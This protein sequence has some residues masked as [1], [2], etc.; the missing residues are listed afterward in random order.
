MPSVDLLTGRV[1]EDT[2]VDLTDILIVTAKFGTF[3]NRPDTDGYYTEVN[4]DGKVDLTDI[5][6]TNNSFGLENPMSW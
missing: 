4:G 6:L 5:L 2:V 3:Q 1:D